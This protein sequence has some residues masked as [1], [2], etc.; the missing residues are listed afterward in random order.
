MF[1]GTEN[2]ETV[3]LLAAPPYESGSGPQSS[4][5]RRCRRR[6]LAGARGYLPTAANTTMHPGHGG[7]GVLRGVERVAAPLL[8]SWHVYAMPS[9]V[10]V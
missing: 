8:A 6:K 5:G 7:E 3:S 1:V 10:I 2:M 9:S 4:D